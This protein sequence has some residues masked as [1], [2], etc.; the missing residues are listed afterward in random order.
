[1]T[2]ID[3]LQQILTM[4]PMDSFARYGLAMEYA[5]SGDV[6]AALAE[7]DRLATDHPDYTPG[8]FMCAQTLAKAGRI[9]E[10]KERLKAGIASAV[11]TR[12]TH[13]EGEMQDMLDDLEN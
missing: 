8:Y 3:M 4:N 9:D 1:M 6:T 2:K 12:N 7:F 11:R 13:A 5:N 10:A